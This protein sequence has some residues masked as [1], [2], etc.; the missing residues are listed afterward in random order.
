[1]DAAE[2][3]E[4]V[5]LTPEELEARITA[6][7]EEINT[8]SDDFNARAAGFL[9]DQGLVVGGE[10]NSLQ[11][12]AIDLKIDEDM[13]LAQGWI[14][15]GGD[16]QRAINIYTDALRLDPENQRLKEAIAT[17]EELRHMT[18]ER[19]DQVKK[20]M[21]QDEVRELLGQVKLRNIREYPEDNVVGWWFR[22][23]DGGAAAIYFK[24][25]KKGDGEWVVYE[26]DFEALKQ[27]VIGGEEASEAGES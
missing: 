16:Y 27:Q 7:E 12:Q 9:N 10:L 14:D 5:P 2:G 24:E 25:K 13:V 1:G 23:A 11:R 20:K 18:K 15:E 17:A 26:A 4:A 21:T 6:L 3:E 8:L 19:F 22:K